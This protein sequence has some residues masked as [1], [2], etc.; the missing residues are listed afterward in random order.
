M[1]IFP[2]LSRLGK[3]AE[4]KP[5]DEDRSKLIT[6]VKGIVRG[7]A[8]VLMG[9]TKGQSNPYRNPRTKQLG[10]SMARFLILVN[11]FEYFLINLLLYCTDNKCRHFERSFP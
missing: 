7:F 2:L 9:I 8:E 10:L 6:R 3:R 4:S 5:N 11:K 1:L